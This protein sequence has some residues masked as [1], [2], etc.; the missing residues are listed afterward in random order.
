MPLRLAAAWFVRSVAQLAEHRFPKPGVAGSIP[1]APV[2][3]LSF[4]SHTEIA[5]QL[6]PKIQHLAVRFLAS[7]LPE[8][9]KRLVRG[10]LCAKSLASRCGFP[11]GWVVG[12]FTKRWVPGFT[13]KR[14]GSTWSQLGWYC[15]ECGFRT[16]L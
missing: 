13:D 10:E 12:N 7:C 16:D 4:L 5:W 3:S 11:F 6:Y 9:Y 8:R 2:E 14:L 1:S 15:W